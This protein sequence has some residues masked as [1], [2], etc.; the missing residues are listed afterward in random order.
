MKME[1]EKIGKYIKQ[2][3]KFLGITQKD[4][5]EIAGIGL[6]TLSDLETGK[7]NPTIDQ[8]IKV[9]DVLGLSLLLKV[10]ANG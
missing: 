5:A 6:R 9:N 3:R 7:G 4:L 1:K 2:R 8:L 10:D